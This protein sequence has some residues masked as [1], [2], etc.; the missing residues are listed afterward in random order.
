MFHVK[1]TNLLSVT[2]VTSVDPV[3]PW[4]TSL[5]LQAREIRRPQEQAAKFIEQGQAISA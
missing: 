4:I 2:S 5:I 3:F 1:L